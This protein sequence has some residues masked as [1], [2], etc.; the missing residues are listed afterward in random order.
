LLDGIDASVILDVMNTKR[1]HALLLSSAIVLLVAGCSG[2]SKPMKQGEAIP[3]SQEMVHAQPKGLNLMGPTMPDATKMAAKDSDD[4]APMPAPAVETANLEPN[5][6][7]DVESRIANLEAQLAA[8]RADYDKIVPT[9]KTLSVNT[10]RLVTL[11]DKLEG[12]DAATVKP[13]AGP[14]LSA[15]AGQAAAAVK[16]I[17]FGEHTGKTR[18]VLD[19]NEITEYGYEVDNVEGIVMIALPDAKW[20][21]GAQSAAFSSPYIESWSY[22]V[23]PDGGTALILQTK[24]P[25][26]ISAHNALPGNGAESPRIYLDISES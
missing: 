18:V 1:V 22:Q 16:K 26:K 25:V 10:D 4:M 7:P 13:A 14:T 11:L 3:P 5:K 2:G 23:M 24:K 15:E 19:L 6:K 9:F 17:R 20:Q 8:L 12:Q 21:A